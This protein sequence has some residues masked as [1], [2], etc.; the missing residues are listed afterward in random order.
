M[1]PVAFATPDLAIPL[2]LTSG[3]VGQFGW[4]VYSINETSLQQAITPPSLLGR[5][6]ATTM[7]IGDGAVP[8][9]ALAGGILG[10]V[11]GLRQA[12]T[13]AAFGSMLSFLWVL[14]SPAQHGAHPGSGVIRIWH[15][16]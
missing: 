15:P 12:I 16:Q 14:F 10:E 7:F 8:L 6:N 1:L 11:L 9:G 3:L 4:T 13:I 2:L 5:V